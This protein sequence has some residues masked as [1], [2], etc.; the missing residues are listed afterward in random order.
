MA[1]TYVTDVYVRFKGDT[2][3]LKTSAKDAGRAVKRVKGDYNSFGRVLRMNFQAWKKFNAEGHKFTSSGARL[4]NRIRMMTHGMRGFRMALLGVMFAG[5]NLNRSM[6][7]LLKPAMQAR[8]ITEQWGESMKSLFLPIIEAVEPVIRSI[9][10]FLSDLPG[11]VKMVIGGFVVFLAALGKVLFLIGSFGLAI[12][13]LIMLLPIF[14]TT[15]TTNAKAGKKVAEAMS[16][17]AAAVFA[18]TASEG[19]NL[20]MT[21]SLTTAMIAQA[22]AVGTAAA[23]QR[24]LN[25]AMTMGASEV[26]PTISNVVK[27]ADKVGGLEKAI[28]GSGL[29]AALKATI[30]EVKKFT[31]SIMFMDFILGK[32][33]GYIRKE[34]KALKGSGLHAALKATNVELKESISNIKYL[35]F[36]LIH[37][38]KR[39][40]L[41]GSIWQAVSE[42]LKS[43]WGSL[44]SSWAS[45]KEGFKDIAVSIS[46][47]GKEIW[48]SIV[49]TGSKILN[50][51]WNFVVGK[52]KEIFNIFK[53]DFEG[54][55][56]VFNATVNWVTGKGKFWDI[57]DAIKDGVTKSFKVRV[58]FVTGLIPEPIK[59]FFGLDDGEGG[60]SGS[61]DANN[62]VRFSKPPSMQ[63]GQLLDQ[64]G[65][66][67]NGLFSS[68]GGIAGRSSPSSSSGVSIGTQYN[69][70]INGTSTKSPGASEYMNVESQN[71]SRGLSE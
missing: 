47:K 68:S 30:P 27:L 35:D 62:K 26:I 56:N 37:S 28:K 6:M 32:S 63:Y 4:G 8:N 38:E 25:A 13:S 1:N 69:Y 49:S 41:F 64:I 24:S 29:H 5:Q 17:S 59:K 44:E 70:F 23:A 46:V 53:T 51:T 10:K 21:L 39:V 7:A 71:G 40:T 19:A 45:F 57:I 52:G 22:V 42:T 34:E 54:L 50:V 33:K 15:M 48:D 58:D 55:A 14:N 2:K 60:I 20:P 11:P 12:G 16:N 67:S 66:D 61:V 18:L 43:V 31:F 36:S 9:G 65:G 3:G